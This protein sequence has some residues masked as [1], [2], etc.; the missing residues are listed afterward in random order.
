MCSGSLWGNTPTAARKMEWPPLVFTVNAQ[1]QRLTLS[2][3]FRYRELLSEEFVDSLPGLTPWY[4]RLC[5][6]LRRFLEGM[7]YLCKSETR[8]IWGLPW[9]DLQHIYCP[10]GDEILKSTTFL[11]ASN[12]QSVSWNQ[13]RSACLIQVIQLWLIL[14]FRECTNQYNRA[15]YLFLWPHCWSIVVPFMI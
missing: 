10:S 13:E 12:T 1:S 14:D 7:L 11:P 8:A 5:W 6:V 9:S 2:L 4:D 15:C 3:S